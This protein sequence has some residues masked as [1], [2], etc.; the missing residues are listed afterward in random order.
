[1]K[2]AEEVGKPENAEA[3]VRER[4]ERHEKIMGFGHAVYRTMDPRA[5]GPEG[6]LAGGG[7]ARTASRIGTRSSR[8]SRRPPSSRRACT[9][10][11]TST[12]PACYHVLGI[13]TD[14]M[15][16]VFAAARMAGW[17]AHVREQYADNKVIRP[18]SASTSAP[19]T[20]ATCRSTSAAEPT[21]PAQPV[22]RG[23]R[24][25]PSTTVPHQ[26]VAAHAHEVDAGRPGDLPEPADDVDRGG[27]ARPFLVGRRPPPAVARSPGARATPAA[28]SDASARVGAPERHDARRAPSRVRT[29]RVAGPGPPSPRRR[30]RRTRSASRSTSAPASSFA[31][32]FAG[33]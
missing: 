13:P 30:P 32:S 18:G 15:T 8:P 4:L 23:N 9:P 17:T 12:P 29:P 10:T 6:A 7:R 16:P 19:A 20:A 27:R 25:A 31:S 5:H 3:V 21:R 11:S 28:L 14:L 1:M 22:G 2:L 24:P 26:V 33:S